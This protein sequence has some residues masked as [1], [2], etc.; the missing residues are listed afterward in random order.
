MVKK[1]FFY[2]KIYNFFTVFFTDVDCLENHWKKFLVQ[3]MFNTMYLSLLAA[4]L[5]QGSSQED[6]EVQS[7]R[8]AIHLFQEQD[9][10]Q[11]IHIFLGSLKGDRTQSP[12][13]NVEQVH[14]NQ[15][16]AIYLE[17][18]AASSSLT[19]Q[20]ILDQYGKILEEHPDYHLLEFLIAAAYA[21]QGK[22]DL[23][24][25]HFYTAYKYHSDHYFAYKTKAILHIKLLERA[26]TEDERIIQRKEI[27][28]NA[29]L[30]VERY[31]QDQSLYKLLIHFSDREKMHDTVTQLLNKIIEKNI[32]VPRSDITYYVRKSLD[33]GEKEL[34]KRFVEKAQ[35]WYKYSR[36]LETAEN[37]LKQEKN[38]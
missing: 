24:F 11:A 12:V 15:A 14:Y 34:A 26:R 28:K 29:Q 27:L 25:D 32:V 33:V 19:A 3:C 13:S 10:E 16:L 31:P 6:A 9:L 2:H 8:K 37:M 7:A 23:F 30:A 1:G 21:N 17:H 22:F 5:L 20:Q 4:I 36:A 35:E 38:Y 18:G